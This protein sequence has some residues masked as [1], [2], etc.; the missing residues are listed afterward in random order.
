MFNVFDSEAVEKRSQDRLH[1]GNS[2]KQV[3]EMSTFLIFQS[4]V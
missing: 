2:Y 3:Y 4:Q 1:Y